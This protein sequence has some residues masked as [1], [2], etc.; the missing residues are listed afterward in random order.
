FQHIG[1]NGPVHL[2]IVCDQQLF[3]FH[4]ILL[5]A[6]RGIRKT[7]SPLYTAMSGKGNGFFQKITGKT[8]KDKS[9]RFPA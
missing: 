7:F 4:S 8:K 5:R 1:Q 9:F 3:S 6:R 2:R